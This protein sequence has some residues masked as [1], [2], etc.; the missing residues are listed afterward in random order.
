MNKLLATI[1]VVP[2]SAIALDATAKDKNVAIQNKHAASSTVLER[3]YHSGDKRWD[4]GNYEHGRHVSYKCFNAWGERI[5]GKFGQQQKYWIELGG[6]RCKVK[7][8]QNF[9]NGV[10]GDLSQIYTTRFPVESVYSAIHQVR[11]EFHI[12]NSRFIEASEVRD[13]LKT[14]NYTLTFRVKGD[15]VRRFRVKHKQYTGEVKRIIEV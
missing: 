6:G 14:Y 7:R 15:G 1:L 4:Y 3:G 11:K 12:P 10:N 9:Y 5:K 8:G 2:L 13:G